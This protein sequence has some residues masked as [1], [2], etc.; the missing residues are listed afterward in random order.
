MLHSGSGRP[1]CVARNS[2]MICL[3]E[4]SSSRSVDLGLEGSSNVR[5]SQGMFSPMSLGE[6]SILGALI[7]SVDIVVDS[8]LGSFTGG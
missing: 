5:L 1:G 8:C 2:G 7:V 3:S 6:G 4:G